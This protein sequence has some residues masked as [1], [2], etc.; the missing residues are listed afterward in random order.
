[1]PI[2]ESRLKTGVLT[3]DS[4]AFAGQATNVALVPNIA[5]DGDRLEVLSGDVILPDEVTTWALEFTGIQD[6]D[7]EDGWINF[8]LTSA[9]DVVP[10]VFTPDD[11]VTGVEYAMTVK[12]RPV[13]IGGGVN[14]RLTSDASWPLQ[15]GPTPSY[16]A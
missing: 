3:I 8:S 2:V 14:V 1:M 11:T 4:V 10:V 9:G 5:E 16:P 7:D 15:T 12:V 6:F 13:T